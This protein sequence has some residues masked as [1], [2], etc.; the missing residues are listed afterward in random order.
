M[1]SLSSR[2][3]RFASSSSSSSTLPAIDH[4]NE[5]GGRRK[6]CMTLACQT[7][8]QHPPLRDLQAPAKGP[9]CLAARPQLDM[10]LR[11]SPVKSAAVTGGITDGEWQGWVVGGE[12]PSLP[13]SE[14]ST[15]DLR[16]Y[17]W[18]S[19]LRSISLQEKKLRITVVFDIGSCS[20]WLHR[21]IYGAWMKWPAINRDVYSRRPSIIPGAPPT[22]DSVGGCMLRPEW[23]LETFIA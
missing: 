3:A 2:S 17:R 6:R 19:W 8:R 18:I 14:D 21:Y 1:A 15:M 22:I 10:Q 7:L 12:T 4:W 9:S 5:S 23:T 11:V 16:T 20:S 13:L